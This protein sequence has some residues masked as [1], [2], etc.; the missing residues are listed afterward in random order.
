M[1]KS[2]GVLALIFSAL[3]VLSLFAG[4]HHLS[5]FHFLRHFALLIAFPA[6]IG[7]WC[8]LSERFKQK[9]EL[10]ARKRARIAACEKEIM[11]LAHIKKG[12]L[13][14]SELLACT[15]MTSEEANE[16]LMELC[17]RRYADIQMTRSGLI[18]Y[19][20]REISRLNEIQEVIARE[21]RLLE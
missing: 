1:K 5:L 21:N 4:H 2:I 13:T 16:A 6:S 18:Y 7:A 11:K 14:V 17:V 15:S 19:E 3:M 20:F 9:R 10:Q 12:R 8:L